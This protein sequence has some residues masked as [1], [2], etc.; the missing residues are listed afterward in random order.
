MQKTRVELKVVP[1]HK[2][3]DKF[4]PCTPVGKTL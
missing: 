3:L 1:A 4:G 2:A